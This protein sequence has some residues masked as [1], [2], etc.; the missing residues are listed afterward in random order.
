MVPIPNELTAAIVDELQ[1]NRES[2]KSCSLVG[3]PFC[4]ASQR[5]LFHSMWLR[6]EAWWLLSRVFAPPQTTENRTPASSIR[7]VSALFS[8]SPHLAT[9]VRHLA[10]DLTTSPDEA[11]L[12]AQIIR[13]VQNL[14]TFAISSTLI[15][16]NALPPALASTILN[17]LARPSLNRV[18][19]WCIE[20]LPASVILGALSS[21]T[22]LFISSGTT[23]YPD[24]EYPPT[25]RPEPQNVSRVEQLL[26]AITDPAT[27]EII[28]SPYAPQ[29][30][31]VTRLMLRADTRTRLCAEV[32]LSS[33]SETLT[34][35]GLDAEG[36]GAPCPLSFPTLPKLR[37]VTLRVSLGVA[38]RF[39]PEGFAGILT[40]LPPAALTI[41]F[42]IVTRSITDPWRDDGPVAGLEN[43]QMDSIRCQLLF[44]NQPNPQL[45]EAYLNAFGTAMREALPGRQLEISDRRD[46]F[47][48]R[49]IVQLQ[50]L[51]CWCCGEKAEK[52]L[53]V[54]IDVL[55]E[56]TGQCEPRAL[57]EGEERLRGPAGQI[58]VEM[59]EILR[60][61]SKKM[62]EGPT[63]AVWTQSVSAAGRVCVASEDYGSHVVDT[64]VT[65]Y[66][67]VT[68]SCFF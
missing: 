3:H 42:S 55:E 15:N 1:H 12:L 16:W 64:T 11:K 57:L 29:L 19:L 37:S 62:D 40:A 30:K 25:T 21:T 58:G 50:V 54:R 59:A 22:V 33:L 45:K 65:Q 60:W 18:H 24:S 17:V 56:T 8:E 44:L 10:V 14:E 36:F 6:P 26:L 63:V 31:H 13:T 27:Y 66:D 35:L 20:N 5:H 4:T 23:A 47:L 7:R 41:V 43:W 32:L 53:G 9:Y 61:R 49:E 67:G 39:I 51:E 68:D 52:F 34:H 46:D 28:L 38:K 48:A 2:L